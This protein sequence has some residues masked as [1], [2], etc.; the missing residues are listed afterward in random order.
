MRTGCEQG[1]CS[2]LTVVTRVA[3]AARAFGD[4]R[5]AYTPTAVDPGQPLTRLTPR[6]A[7]APRGV[8]GAS[9]HSSGLLD[10]DRRCLLRCTV[11]CRLPIALAGSAALT[12]LAIR[13][14]NAKAR[15]PT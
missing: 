3:V 12:Q 2:A 10:V 7:A 4:D 9:C 8:A 6:P 5:S 11:S 13:L 14:C 15:R 1:T